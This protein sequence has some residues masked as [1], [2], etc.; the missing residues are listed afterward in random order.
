MLNMILILPIIENVHKVNYTNFYAYRQLLLTPFLNSSLY[1]IKSNMLS[2]KSKID[3]VT[4]S[5]IKI[6]CDN[7]STK[8][9]TTP[10]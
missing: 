4:N 8:L 7:L 5:E 10:L 6:K 1:M 3:N 9:N 2:R